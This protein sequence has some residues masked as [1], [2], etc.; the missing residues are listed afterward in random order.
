MD[1]PTVGRAFVNLPQVFSVEHRGTISG[2][3]YLTVVSMG[4]PFNAFSGT[5]FIVVID[6]LLGTRAT[7]SFSLLTRWTVS[8]IVPSC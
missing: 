1:C 8:C 2:P 5:S 4:R 7:W 3:P 6:F